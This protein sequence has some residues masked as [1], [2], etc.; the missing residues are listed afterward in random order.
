MKPEAVLLDLSINMREMTIRGLMSG[1]Y[2]DFGDTP[3][4]FQ[5]G[6]YPH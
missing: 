3:I 1:R 5:C 2:G 6:P 4:R